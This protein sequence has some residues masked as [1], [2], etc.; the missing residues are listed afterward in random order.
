[1]IGARW[2]ALIG[3]LLFGASNIVGCLA[4]NSLAGLFISGTLYGLGGSIMY[5]LSNS[6][7]VQWFSTRLGTAKGLVKLGGAIAAAVMAI[8]VQLLIERVGIS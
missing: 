4:V 2:T 3:T 1:M 5:T 7:P 8:V 6:L